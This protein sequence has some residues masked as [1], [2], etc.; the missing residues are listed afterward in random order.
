M[1]LSNTYQTAHSLG[2]AK[3]L[4]GYH[5]S[6][7]MVGFLKLYSYVCAHTLHPVV[8]WHFWCSKHWCWFDTHSV[9][10]FPCLQ[11]SQRHL[12]ISSVAFG[13]CVVWEVCCVCVFECWWVDGWL[14]GRWVFEWTPARTYPICQT[15]KCKFVWDSFEIWIF[16]SFYLPHIHTHTLQT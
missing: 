13:L 3:N 6:V 7:C 1:H 12:H 15:F 8:L 11:N 2:V 14:V 16:L 10:K 9:F 4:W 5:V